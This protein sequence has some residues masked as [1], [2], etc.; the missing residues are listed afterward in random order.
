MV[1]NCMA[2][3]M[4][5]PSERHDT[6]NVDK[7]RGRPSSR[8]RILKAAAELAREVGAGNFSLDAVAERA[9][10]SKGGLL[11]NFPTKVELLRALVANHVDVLAAQIA[12][13]QGHHAGSPNALVH[14]VIDSSCLAAGGQMAKPSGIL[15]AIAQ[16]PQ[17]LDPVREHVRWL[18]QEIRRTSSSPDR[19]LIAILA[20]EGL[21]THDLFEYGALQSEERERLVSSLGRF[22]E[23]D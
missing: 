18:M 8:E 14:A 3:S 1:G 12:D 7:R 22:V 20:L 10:V 23:G 5:D 9:G 2:D 21:R 16:D 6:A 4:A 15:A 13:A 17:L 11:Y 19:A